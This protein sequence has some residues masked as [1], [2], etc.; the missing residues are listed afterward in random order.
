MSGKRSQSDIIDLVDDQEPPLKSAFRTASTEDVPNNNQKRVS[1]KR[2]ATLRI[3][4]T[5]QYK[6]IPTPNTDT[7]IKTE[8]SPL[9]SIGFDESQIS[10]SGSTDSG[11]DPYDLLL[12]PQS[13][14]LTSTPRRNHTTHGFLNC[15]LSPSLL[16]SSRP[17]FTGPISAP[18]PG[19]NSDFL[20]DSFP[21]RSF[22]H[23]NEFEHS[24]PN[25]SGCHTPTKLPDPATPSNLEVF[26]TASPPWFPCQSNPPA[27]LL[28]ESPDIEAQLPHDKE[29]S[30]IP[31]SQEPIA[32]DAPLDI[33]QPVAESSHQTSLDTAVA[34]DDSQLPTV[35]MTPGFS[36]YEAFNNALQPSN[37]SSF[38]EQ[39]DND[40][41]QLTASVPQLEESLHDK[42]YELQAH[43]GAEPSFDNLS[44]VPDERNAPACLQHNQPSS[45]EDQ[46]TLDSRVHTRVL[47]SE[48]ASDSHRA[49]SS[50][51][52]HNN[53]DS[54][55]MPQL[56]EHAAP[57]LYAS[58][59]QRLEPDVAHPCFEVNFHDFVFAGSQY[60]ASQLESLNGLPGAPQADSMNILREFHDTGFNDETLGDSSQ[61]VDESIAFAPCPQY[62]GASPIDLFQL[63][64]QHDMQNIGRKT[65]RILLR[66]C[67]QP[68]LASQTPSSLA[69]PPQ[70]DGSG[71][72]HAG[73]KADLEVK[74]DP[75]F[76]SSAASQ[77]APFNIDLSPPVED[78]LGHAGLKTGEI[79]V[80][81]DPYAP[82]DIDDQDP[83]FNNEPHSTDKVGLEDDDLKTETF[84]D[85]V[86]PQSDV[87]AQH[88]PFNIEPLPV[89]EDALDH[90][91]LKTEEIQVIFSPY[92]QSDV[93]YQSSPFNKESHS[94]DKAGLESNHF[95]PGRLQAIVGPELASASQSA[96][97]NFESELMDENELGVDGLETGRIGAI[98]ELQSPIALNTPCHIENQSVDEDAMETED[99]KNNDLKSGEIEVIVD[100]RSATASQTHSPDIA[101]PPMQEHPLE[102]EEIDA[103]TD[104]QSAT[105]SQNIPT[106]IFQSMVE[107]S[108][109]STEKTSAMVDSSAQPTQE[110]TLEHNGL[111]AGEMEVSF[112]PC[113]PPA[114]SPPSALQPFDIGPIQ[115]PVESLALHQTASATQPDGTTPA[116]ESNN[117]SSE[118]LVTP[119][120]PF[121]SVLTQLR[122]QS[123]A[124]SRLSLSLTNKSSSLQPQRLSLPAVPVSE[125][126]LNVMGIVP[127]LKSINIIPAPPSAC[128]Q[129]PTFEHVPTEPPSVSQ[130]IVRHLQ[131]L[132]LDTLRQT[133]NKSLNR[134]KDM[135][136]QIA[137]LEQSIDSGKNGFIFDFGYCCKDGKKAKKDKLMRNR[138]YF[139][140]ECYV[141]W[142]DI[143]HSQLLAYEKTLRAL[144]DSVVLD[145]R[146]LKDTQHEAHAIKEQAQA[147]YDDLGKR[148][149]FALLNLKSTEFTTQETIDNLKG[150]LSRLRQQVAL[151]NAALNDARLKRK[152]GESELQQR[153]MNQKALTQ[154]LDG[155]RGKIQAI[156][157]VSP[158]KVSHTKEKYELLQK[159]SLWVPEPGSLPLQIHLAST[160]TF[161]IPS[162]PIDPSA[163]QI[164]CRQPPS[165]ESSMLLH[166]ICCFTTRLTLGISFKEFL[167]QVGR[168]WFRIRS[169]TT[170]V[171]CLQREYQTQ[172][173]KLDDGYKV[174]VKF[175]KVR[176]AL[177]TCLVVSFDL[178][179]SLLNSS[180]PDALLPSSVTQHYGPPHHLPQ[181]E[182]ILRSACPQSTLADVCRTIKASIE[183]GDPLVPGVGGLI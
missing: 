115:V 154:E 158:L 18:M 95:Q 76:Q 72:E 17:H 13:S 5:P 27:P 106:S 143:Y 166:L 70:I 179:T 54:N 19:F 10:I 140:R 149:T 174:Q 62:A 61:I 15:E 51:E 28:K 116:L 153:Q 108:G 98:V 79:Q 36:T 6:N 30:A 89:D 11:E 7:E 44:Q 182:E 164:C 59:G 84:D 48:Q 26:T 177:P 53:T 39:P 171:R 96:T 165:H 104:P 120:P 127:F 99:Y 56:P 110:S 159:T 88:T 12:G 137:K 128:L 163:I 33:H 78:A 85:M 77:H 92:A 141:I 64:N 121:N 161:T 2:Q 100:P 34:L 136:L 183:T 144:H 63:M 103:I 31:L 49:N 21:R 82:S 101:S 167:R 123:I 111:R 146:L 176:C 4:L 24:A 83:P 60:G 114:V 58:A 102:T 113:I 67:A 3:L 147:R 148:Q 74:V 169:I 86:D 71:L 87:T 75:E 57:L 81:F 142:S 22:V 45:S 112:D 8:D 107:N 134:S 97:C 117:R 168:F 14:R 32:A 172:L 156:P 181:V 152:Q 93:E 9:A 16:G 180:A 132:N 1:F 126:K 43:L 65:G 46:Q 135:S 157:Y 130:T 139:S 69:K 145:Y 91:G 173:I 124:A 55:L 162:T 94:M 133:I 138:A 73:L 37:A 155:I 23:L 125:H 119:G 47:D 20:C 170:Q 151:K 122:E 118:R 160:L 38:Q 35:P 41:Q 150:S 90:V 175:A 131:Q 25:S 129:L 52:F 105:T 50:L 178:S 40:F 68:D 80:I 29:S 109:S 66:S 42:P